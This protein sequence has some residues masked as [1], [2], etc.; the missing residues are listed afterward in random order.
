MD[1]RAW[2]RYGALGGVW[3]VVL[4]LIGGFMAGS[5]QPGRTDSPAEIAEWLADNDTALQWGAF[6]TGIGVIGLAWWFGTLYRAM[7]DAEDGRPR[8]A[9]IA[10]VGLTVSGIGAMTGFAINA[11][12][13]S[14]ADQAADTAGIFY[15]IA[16]TL[17]A[18]SAIGDV[19]L[20]LAVS[21]LAMRSGFLP[22]WVTYLGLVSVVASLIAALGIVSSDDF[23]NLFGFLAFLVW[24]LWLLSVSVVNYQRSS[25]GAESVSS[26]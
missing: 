25:T 6:L 21:G 26:G 7:R 16:S 3:F 23:F 18:F 1:D 2:E 11:G 15:G 10:L 22:R 12:V 13:A 17:L 9:I 19:I 20:V 24:A 14:V 4:A 5:D 8:V